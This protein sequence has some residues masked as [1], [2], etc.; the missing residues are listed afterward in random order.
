MKSGHDYRGELTKALSRQR[1]AIRKWQAGRLSHGEMRL[2]GMAAEQ[3]AKA[4]GK[5][6]WSVMNKALAKVYGDVDVVP[7][8]PL[9]SPAGGLESWLPS[10]EAMRGPC[11]RG[12]CAGPFCLVRS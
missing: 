12:C 3:K 10:P 8:H 9:L 5:W 2:I 4:R 6:F 1:K 11:P 7:K